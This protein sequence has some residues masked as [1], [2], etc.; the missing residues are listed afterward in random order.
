MKN[1]ALIFALVVCFSFV[2]CKKNQTGELD[3]VIQTQLSGV[4]CSLLDPFTNSSGQQLKIELLKFYV[5]NVILI[6]KKGNEKTVEDIALFEI[7][8]AG[9]SNLT[10]TAP[11]GDYV[12]LKFSIGVPATM[13]EADP[14]SYSETGHPLNTTEGMYWDMNAMYRFVSMD[15]RY[16][17]EPDGTDDGI[18]SYHTGFNESFRT[19]QFD[20][21]KSVEKDEITTA[22]IYID[23]K[24]ILATAGNELDVVNEPFYHGN[25]TDYFLSTM[26][27]DN[28]SEAISV[29]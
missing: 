27:S 1:V 8:A 29:Q 4:D 10:M 19:V 9:T 16:D 13:N 23:L 14:S 6:D 3:F 11:V 26:I 20:F 22:T 18:F 5:S 28:F 21:A 25:T 7:D 17:L 24:K 2:S 15:G 12:S